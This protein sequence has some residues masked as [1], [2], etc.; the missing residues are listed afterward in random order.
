MYFKSSVKSI[1]LRSTDF[2]YSWEIA[3][4]ISFIDL[5]HGMNPDYSSKS[6]AIIFKNERK[7]CYI[8][9]SYIIKIKIFIVITLTVL[10]CQLFFSFEVL[11]L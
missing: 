10:L 6:S 11:C 2:F 3:G 4:Y 1:L 8:C 9:S 5:K 7:N